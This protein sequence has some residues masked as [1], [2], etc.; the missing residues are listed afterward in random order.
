[1][2][3]KG[4]TWTKFRPIYDP[5]EEMYLLGLTGDDIAKL[6]PVSRDICYR[7]LRKL[8]IRLVHGEIRYGYPMRKHKG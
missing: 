8:G 6:L 1:M 7:R 5:M 4:T 2:S 3:F